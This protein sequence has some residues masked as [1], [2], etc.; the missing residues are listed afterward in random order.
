VKYEGQPSQQLRQ[1]EDLASA[2]A[3]M[4]HVVGE[5]D[6]C[7]VAGYPYRRSRPPPPALFQP[8]FTWALY[9]NA[10]TSI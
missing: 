9:N 1:G 2:L 4:E 6:T 7:R 3:L 10:P 5:L 8:T